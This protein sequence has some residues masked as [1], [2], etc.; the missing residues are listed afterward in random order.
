M[1]LVTLHNNFRLFSHSTRRA[2]YFKTI[3]LYSGHLLTVIYSRTAL[4]EAELEYNKSHESWSIFVAFQLAKVPNFLASILPKNAQVGALIWTTTPWTLPANQAICYSPKHEYCIVQSESHGKYFLVASDMVD[5]AQHHLKHGLKVLT[6]FPGALLKGVTYLHPLHPEREQCLIEGDHVTMEKGTGLVHSAPNHGLEDYQNTQKHKIPLDECLVDEKGCFT[7]GAGEHLSGHE[8]L[9]SGS[10]VVMKLLEDRI[11]HVG[12]YTHSYPYDW[13]SK[14]PI[15]VR[16]SRQWFINLDQLRIR[17]IECLEGVKI[18][19]ESARNMFVN[20]LEQRPHWCISRQRYWG[21]PIPVLFRDKT[22]LTSRKFVDHLCTLVLQEGSDIWWTAPMD[23]LVTQE[24]RD[25]LKLAADEKIEKGCDI[26]DIWLD[27]GLSWKMVL[28]E[29]KQAD[30]YLEG[31]DQIRGWFQ[32]SLITSVALRNQ[33]PYKHIFLH[34]FTLDSEGRKMSKSLGNVTDPH[35]VM[36]GGKDPKLEPAYGVDVLRWWVASHASDNENVTVAQHIF[37]ECHASVS[38][39]RNTLRF[40]LGALQDFSHEMHLCSYEDL[41]PVDQFMLHLL[42]DF[43]LKVTSRYED[44]QYNHACSQIMNFVVNEA[45]SFYFQAVKDRLYCDASNSLTRRS[46]QTVLSHTLDVLAR[47]IAPVLPHLCEEVFLHHPENK[48]AK[49]GLFRRRWQR[50]PSHWEEKHFDALREPLW[51]LREAV[52]KITGSNSRQHD[53]IISARE[54]SP[55]LNIIHKLQV[56]EVAIHSGLT[57]ILQ[58]ASVRFATCLEPP[59]AKGQGSNSDTVV[60]DEETGLQVTALPTTYALCGRCR[61]HI[62]P[63]VGHL[64]KRCEEVLEEYRLSL[65]VC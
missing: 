61:R 26:M 21:V 41:L 56:E 23:K 54:N 8:V 60:L 53:V 58:V 65:Q 1:T 31:G 11:E 14:K 38:K 7:A 3:S 44:L 52:N 6:K 32:S 43:N 37:S 64:C 5:S 30:I 42:Y 45:S 2:T 4:A 20:Q 46:C 15:I 22:A 18:T 29:S 48:C 28:P 62:S 50:L 27:S 51:G 13:R 25:D 36:N 55:Q 47:L 10:H 19:P 40:C 39:L 59:Q 35:T 12:K 33:A 63:S 49:T 34:G 9:G 24:I 57:D 17:A 16:S